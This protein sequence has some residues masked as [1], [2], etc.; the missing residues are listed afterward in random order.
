LNLNLT[1]IFTWLLLSTAV[2]ATDLEH[3]S[4][5]SAGA[6]FGF[7]ATHAARGFRA[8]EA[9]LNCNLPFYWELGARS[10]L[11]IRVDFTAGWLGRDGE[12]AAMGGAG[13]TLVYQYKGIPLSLEGGSSSTLL[14]AHRFSALDLGGTFQ[15]TTHL[16]L[17]W[18]ITKRW[19]LGYR[20]QHTS[21]AGLFNH[22]PG[23]NIH[24]FGLS[25]VF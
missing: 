18:E 14:S 16:G 13:P 6:R 2:H 1:A 9:F 23:L 19:R 24:S 3:F 7:G 4:I 25:Y 15:F 12:N 21:N 11:N 20:Y 10:L 17:N 5:E 8:G 22:N